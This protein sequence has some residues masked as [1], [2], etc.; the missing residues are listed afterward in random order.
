MSAARLIASLVSRTAPPSITAMVRAIRRASASRSARGTTRFT[1]PI[2]CA[3][4][5][6]SRSLPVSRTSFARFGPTTHGRIRVTIPLPNRSSGSPNTA[7]S[8][9]IVMSQATASS[10]A[11][12]RQ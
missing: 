12:A 2:A 1:R 7:S 8:A 3:S 4:P 10:H 9:A 5:A 11:P 6:E